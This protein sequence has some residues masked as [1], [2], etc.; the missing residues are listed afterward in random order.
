VIP[1]LILLAVLLVGALSL[2]VPR[3]VRSYRRKKIKS[4]PFPKEWR[5]ILKRRIPYFRQMPADLQ[6]QLKKHIQVFV[7]EKQF[8]G[9]QGIEIDDDIR[10]TVAAQA[11][12]LLLNR[13]TDYFPKLKYVYV[14]P[15]AFYRKQQ[16]VDDAGV[17]HDKKQVLLGESW[18]YGKV[19]LSWDDTVAG[20]ANP[21]DGSN[22][23][24]H[25]FAH[26]LDHESGTTNGAP[27]L[28][29]IAW[30]TDWSQVFQQEFERLQTTIRHGGDTLLGS[31]AATNPAEFFAVS[32]EVF[33][34]KSHQ[35]KRDHDKLYHQ[36]SRYY[37]VDPVNW[38]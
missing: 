17:H 22:V 3:F 35:L 20:A 28:A 38:S 23:V 9:F 34:E 14:Y 19:I 13:S 5:D 18:D 11:C 2:I 21:I 37:C 1:V 31:Y 26:Q 36:L 4:K 15:S 30:Y 29:K 8:K 32:S 16:V 25:E 33:F 7:A 27:I 24:I 6:L 12:L 10:V